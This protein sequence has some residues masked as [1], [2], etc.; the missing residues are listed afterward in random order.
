MSCRFEAFDQW[1]LPEG[2]TH[3]QGWM[4]TQ[5]QRR[6]GRLGYQ[7]HKYEAALALLPPERRRHAVDV[8]AHVGLWS[9]YMAHDFQQLTAFEPKLQHL[10][11]WHLNLAS[12]RLQPGPT[13]TAVAHGVALGRTTGLVGLC[14]GPASSGDTRVVPIDLAP[15]PTPVML[16]RLDD[17]RLTD[18]DLLK[19]DCEG[20]ELFVVEG[21]EETI[22]R[23]KPVVVVEQKRGHGVQYDERDDAAQT[24][25]ARWGART[26]TVLSGD[27]VMSWA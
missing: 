13:A 7:L 26:V 4:T 11:L 15:H 10:L 21:G 25:L 16:K 2:E 17:Y 20:Y 12:E 19:I 1:L 3:L 18:V 14:T 9:Y 24:L 8:G 6:L 27:V 22:R 5:Q 23:C